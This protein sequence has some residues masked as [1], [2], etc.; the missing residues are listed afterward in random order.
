VASTGGLSQAPQYYECQGSIRLV[1]LEKA[2]MAAIVQYGQLEPDRW[3][4][5]VQRRWSADELPAGW[6]LSSPDRCSHLPQNVLLRGTAAGDWPLATTSADQPIVSDLVGQ[7]S[8][9]YWSSI[10]MALRS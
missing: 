8:Y 2:W 4:A 7:L 3:T 6:R 9:R 1:R 10:P 5:L